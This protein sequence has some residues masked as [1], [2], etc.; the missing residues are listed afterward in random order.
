MTSTFEPNQESV[1]YLHIYSFNPVRIKQ[2][3]GE[4]DGHLGGAPNPAPP[5]GKK[6][7]F[8]D[9]KGPTLKVGP[10]GIGVVNPFGKK[11][12]QN[13]P[14]P[15]TPPPK[16]QPSAP[17]PKQQPSAPPP[18]QQPPPPVMPPRNTNASHGPSGG[19]NRAPAHVPP[20]QNSA[21]TFCGGCGQ[22][23]EP[24]HPFCGYC[25]VKN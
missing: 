14:P 19:G 17:P 13:Q 11:K 5:P 2:I 7:G 21:P 16:Q 9:P 12:P 10:V 24:G 3:G 18:K 15:N 23:L 22:R 6:P 4:K 25:G 1:F 20:S 8:A